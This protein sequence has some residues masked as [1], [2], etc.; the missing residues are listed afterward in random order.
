MLQKLVDVILKDKKSKKA[1][2]KSNTSHFCDNDNSKSDSEP[3]LY[4]I[5][6]LNLVFVGK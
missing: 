4:G 1:T 5:D 3:E 6:R 2:F